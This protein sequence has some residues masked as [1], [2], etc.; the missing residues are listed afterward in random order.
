MILLII[1]VVLLVWLFMSKS[2][3]RTCIDEIKNIKKI[4]VPSL[5]HVFENLKL[6]HKPD[7]LWLEFGVFSGGSINYISKFTSNTVYG[8]DSFE[9]LPEKWR[10][11]FDKGAFDVNG[12][13]PA[14]N[15]NVKLVKGW[16]N[17]TLIPFLK[18][19]NKKISFMHI[20]C[21]LYSS[22]IFALEACR[23]YFTDDC[24]IVFDELVGYEGYD[25]ENGEAKAWCEFVNKYNIK[26][27]YIGTHGETAVL[28]LSAN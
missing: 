25:G 11:G 1:Y 10:E 6:T 7:T 12:K 8:F 13:L 23:P 20:D 5:T 22:S 26:F 28:K 14:V 24:I 18:E 16:F 21:D 27:K 3:L 15:E 9:G 17:E 4:D 2:K 19:Q